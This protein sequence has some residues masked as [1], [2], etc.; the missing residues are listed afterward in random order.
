M[1]DA[2][3]SH[4]L[5]KVAHCIVYCEVDRGKRKQYRRNTKREILLI[6]PDLRHLWT[7]S[8]KQWHC[9][10]SCSV[11]C[12]ISIHCGWNQNS[13]PS[14]PPFL[15]PSLHPSLL[16]QAPPPFSKWGLRPGVFQ[17][18]PKLK[19]RH[20]CCLRGARFATKKKQ[21]QNNALWIS[22][23]RLLSIVYVTQ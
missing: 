7:S 8:T 22:Q 3:S 13:S 11:T 2:I 4:N 19:W 10:I 12:F 1:L 6:L 5:L 9:L 14:G 21:Q 15:P 23:S 17:P 20:N 16:F 18:Q